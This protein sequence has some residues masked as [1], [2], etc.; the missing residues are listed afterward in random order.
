MPSTRAESPDPSPRKEPTVRQAVLALLG[1]L[2]LLA[3][4]IVVAVGDTPDVVAVNFG[5]DGTAN[6]FASR[7]S[8]LPLA[9]GVSIVAA[10]LL[11]AVTWTGGRR[12]PAGLRWVTGLP[13]GIVWTV[14]GVVV[15][16][17][18]PQRGLD[19][20][21]SA[22]VGPWSVVL[23][24]VLGVA[25]TVLVGRM[26]DLPDPPATTDAAP[27]GAARVDLPSTTTV[28]WRGT[29][30]TGT[31]MLTVGVVVLAVAAVV[32]AVVAE[33]WVGA[34]MAVAAVPLAASTRFRVTLGP[35]GL[36]VAG[37]LAGWPRLAIPLDTVTGA[38]TTTIRPF[39][40]GGWGLRMQ[41]G[42][43]TTAVVTRSGPALRLR[44]T[45]DT[46]IIVSLDEP[47]EVAAV[48]N[49]LL[50]R[51]STTPGGG[52]GADRAN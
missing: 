21:T 38:D 23:A 20:A 5:A 6:S 2:V 45:D 15:A 22:T 11:A 47:G 29:T 37:P 49:G 13:V 9:L 10:G 32:V 52:R 12:P 17:L 50:D 51:R 1:S 46:T 34:I 33:W 25:V 18:L 26:V 41:P 30:P 35:G 27:D 44:R 42:T 43:G 24:L 7:S 39:E 19:D 16:T 3:V 28:L 8:V 48:A 4:A 31:G 40:Y 14:G 36:Q